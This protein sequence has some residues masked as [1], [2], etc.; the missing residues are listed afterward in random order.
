MNHRARIATNEV[1]RYLRTEQNGGLLLLIATALALTIANSPMSGV[2][3]R[4]TETRLGPAALQLDL[5]I[6]DWVKD[7]LLALFFVVAGLELKREL[8]VGELRDIRHA[9]LPIA[10]AL[11]GMVAPA[12]IFL[13]IAAGSPGATRGWAVPVAT[14]IAFALAVLA[15]TAKALP[16]SVRVFLLSLAI[17]DDLGAILLIATIFTDNIAMV[18]L[19]GSA[20]MIALYALLQ[21]RRVRGWWIYWPLGLVAW[22]LLHASGVHATVAGVAVG[23]VTRVK[24]DRDE[25][26]SPAEAL[27]HR[28]QPFSAGVCVPLFAF[29]AA[30]VALSPE[31]LRAFTADR[32]AWAIV[33]GLVVGKAIGVLGGTALAVRSGAGRLPSDLGWWDL[34]AVSVLAGCG[35]TVSMLITELAF[36]GDQQDRAKTAVLAGSL[37]ASLIAAVLLRRRVRHHA[38][39]LRKALDLP[40]AT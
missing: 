38:R 37:L 20:A 31:A 18:P 26:E 28:L 15:V 22:G 17:I 21:Q 10:G 9:L 6:G 36:T 1:A 16:A 2:Y 7:G 3:E 27:E 12:V 34:F 39:P 35:F 14:D 23:L 4:V 5:T 24:H 33:A 29:F 8:V 19:V 40:P 30:G 13:A 32:I 25:H 11:G